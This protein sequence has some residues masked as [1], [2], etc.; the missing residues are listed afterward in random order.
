MYAN[1][2]VTMKAANLTTGRF[3]E[4]GTVSMEAVSRYTYDRNSGS[5]RL[6]GEKSSRFIR[7]P[8]PLDW[9]IAANALPGKAGAIGLAL[10]FL[11]GVRGSRTIKLTRQIERI[12]GC[13]RKAI[14][15]AL[16]KLECAG[17]VVIVDRQVGERATIQVC[18]LPKNNE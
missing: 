6:Q 15:A 14:Y 16:S 4:D 11:V 10:W 9:V 12:A 3:A 1:K 5:Y 17:L 8:I 7:G 18:D 13:S 2:K